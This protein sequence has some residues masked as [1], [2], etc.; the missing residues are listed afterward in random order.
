MDKKIMGLN[1]GKVWQALNEVKEIS[2]PESARKSERSDR[3]RIGHLTPFQIC[4]FTSI[5]LS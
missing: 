5:L 3:S 2:I 1:A 4:F